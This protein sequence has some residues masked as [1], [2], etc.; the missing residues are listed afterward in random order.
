MEKLVKRDEII[1]HLGIWVKKLEYRENDDRT[2]AE[3]HYE[4]T[5]M[6]ETPM[7]ESVDRGLVTYGLVRELTG[8]LAG[9]FCD[10]HDVEEFSC[11][12]RPVTH[13]GRTEDWC[14]KV[15]ACVHLAEAD[16]DPDERFDGLDDPVTDE[17]RVVNVYE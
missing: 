7:C 15:D 17:G 16:E 12:I 10:A 4:V 6:A 2:D 5:G 11:G 9:R 8:R 13:D 14:L 3:L 1:E